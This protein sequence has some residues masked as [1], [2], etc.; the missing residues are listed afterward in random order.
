[1]IRRRAPRSKLART[2]P[3]NFDPANFIDRARDTLSGIRTFSFMLDC[4]WG[5]FPRMDPSS[6]PYMHLML[7]CMNSPRL[8]ALVIHIPDDDCSG[9]ATMKR[10]APLD[11]LLQSKFG[12]VERLTFVPHFDYLQPSSEETKA[13][14]ATY[15]PYASGAGM[16]RW[17]AY[18]P[19]DGE[20]F[21]ASELQICVGRPTDVFEP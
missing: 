13:A 19:D 4:R 14:V 1:M 7:A 18:C 16:V 6:F 3:L 9:A 20:R 11:D 5:E 17:S 12:T 10:C 21:D 2:S 8:T 15:F